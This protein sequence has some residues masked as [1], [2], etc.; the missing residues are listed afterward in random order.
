MYNTWILAISS[1]LISSATKDEKCEKYA[2][3]NEVFLLY[4]L[5]IGWGP[6]PMQ[7]YFVPHDTAFSAYY[8]FVIVIARPPELFGK[9][10]N[11]AVNRKRCRCNKK[12]C[13]GKIQ[14]YKLWGFYVHRVT[15]FI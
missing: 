8:T 12:E 14:V 10:T 2:E 5:V 7:Q 1:E 4:L 6:D 11:Q 15:R 9:Y 13:S 3:A